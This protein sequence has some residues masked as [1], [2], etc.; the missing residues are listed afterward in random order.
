MVDAF[1]ART[2]LAFMHLF[3]LPQNRTTL[4]HHRCLVHFYWIPWFINLSFL[5]LISWP[6]QFLSQQQKRQKKKKSFPV[7]S[8]KGLLSLKQWL[9][10]ESN[11]KTAV[12]FEQVVHIGNLK[13]WSWC[14]VVF[15]VGA[16]EQHGYVIFEGRQLYSR[17]PQTSSNKMFKDKEYT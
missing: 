3:F 2:D 13:P 14:K 4:A 9:R 1:G 7:A 6:Q 12:T 17:C 10:K 5:N 8:S 15:P 16:W 11:V